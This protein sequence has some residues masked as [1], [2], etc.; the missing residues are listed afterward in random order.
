YVCGA[1]QVEPQHLEV[2]CHVLWEDPG[3][4]AEKCR[5]VVVSIANPVG[6]RVA[7]L[8]AEAD[9]ISRTVNPSQAKDVIK[10]TEQLREIFRQLNAL[11]ATDGRVQ[12]AK[13]FVTAVNDSIKAEHAR[14]GI[15]Q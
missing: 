9:Q 6:P 15:V 10:G 11:P 1:S 4:Q 5:K 13:T 7:Q 12:S 3:E 8:L 14:R 2:L